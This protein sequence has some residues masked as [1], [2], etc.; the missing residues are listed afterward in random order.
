[1]TLGSSDKLTPPFN[2][3]NEF[4]AIKV[5][6]GHMTDMYERAVVWEAEALHLISY[7]PTSPHCPRLLDEFMIPGKGSADSHVCFVMPVYGG[8]VKGLMQA[9][10]TTLPLPLV[11]RIALHMLR[12]IAHA[13]ERRVVHTDLKTDNI[14]FTTTMTKDDIEGW[15]TNDP[16]RRHAPEVSYDGVVQAAV[17]QPL[18]MIIGDEAMGATYLLADFGCGMCFFV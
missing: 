9:R 18:P 10:A 13:H 14:F 17:S 7:R 6:T 5:L 4:V 15:V 12:G 8:D 2:S 16:S 3:T 11:K 1:V